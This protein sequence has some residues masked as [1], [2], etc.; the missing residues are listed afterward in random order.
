MPCD[1]YIPCK[2]EKGASARTRRERQGERDVPW[3]LGVLGWAMRW[4]GGWK[5]WMLFRK[6][7]G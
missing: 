6:S 1:R 4:N 5:F 2:N 7:Y 3:R